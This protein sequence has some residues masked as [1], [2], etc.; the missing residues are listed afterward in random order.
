MGIL[1]M[2]IVVYIASLCFFLHSCKKENFVIDNL[3]GNSIDIMGHAGMGF[4]NLY[5]INSLESILNCINLDADGTEIDVQL[6][7]DGVLIAF[8]DDNLS[9]STNTSGV[10][11]SMN[12]EE[13][14][15]A[16]Y[17]ST[18][19]STHNVIRLDDVFSAIQ[20]QSSKLFTL[21]IK[22]YTESINYPAYYDDY[23]NAIILFFDKYDLAN[24]V[25]IESQSKDFLALMKSKKSTFQ[26][27]HY[28]QTFEEGIGVVEEIGIKGISISTDAITKEQIQAAHNKGIFVTLWNVNSKKKNKEAIRKNA[29]MIQTDKVKHLVKLLN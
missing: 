7:K 13:I 17:N 14:K 20:D 11:R 1:K 6:S 27:Y 21:D 8:H 18:P 26:L 24:H 15:N 9:K 19:L 12:W 22:L 5:P 16:K 29:D 2:K 3:N 4:S 28:P 23:T 10:I 25:Y